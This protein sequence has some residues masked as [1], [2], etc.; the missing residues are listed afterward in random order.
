MTHHRHQYLQQRKDIH[1]QEFTLKIF[2]VGN[3]H[4]AQYRLICLELSQFTLSLAPVALT[5]PSSLLSTIPRDELNKKSSEQLND[6]FPSTSQTSELS[7]TKNDENQSSHDPTKSIPNAKS[8]TEENTSNSAV[9]NVN[10]Y[11]LISI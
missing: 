3:E 6:R 9:E 2:N 8:S 1:V 4:I 5:P 7:S 11:F 10:D